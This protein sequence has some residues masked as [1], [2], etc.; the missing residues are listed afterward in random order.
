MR[1]SVFIVSLLITAQCFTQ[2]EVSTIYWGTCILD[3]RFSPFQVLSSNAVSS[4][5]SGASICDSAGNLLFYSNGGTSPTSN[6]TGGA[7][8]ANGQFLQN[9]QNLEHLGCFS[10]QQ[11]AIILPDPAGISA[12]SKKYYLLTKD[13]IEAAFTGPQSDHSG[14]SYGI[15]D[16]LA[17]GGNGAVI[18]QN[19]VVV[20]YLNGG[21]STD[22]EPLNVVLDT[23]DE[24]KSGALGYW[25]YSYQGDSLYKIHFGVNGFD[26]FQTLFQEGGRIIVAPD[27]THL[28]I[29]SRLY[30]LDA[31][32]G[33][34]VLVHTFPTTNDGVFSSDGRKIY[35]AENN[36]LMQYNMDQANWQNTPYEVASFSQTAPQFFLV[37]SGRIF[38]WNSNSAFSAQIMCPNTF[39]PNCNYTASNLSL[40]GGSLTTPPNIPAH[41]LYNAGS[42]CLLGLDE[43]AAEKI[44]LVPNPSTGSFKVYCDQL[45]QSQLTIRITDLTGRVIRTDKAT[46]LEV[47]GQLE[48][49]AEDLPNGE[50][51]LEFVQK[52]Q[53]PVMKRFVIRQ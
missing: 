11:G 4:R 20:P 38:L 34:L 13:C 45:D 40:Q 16:M 48:I 42:G 35:R 37:P 14:L 32:T 9:G 23:D 52:D 36:K 15:I 39:G 53:E 41:Y 44:S 33:N 8:G 31:P 50:Y 21:G 22:W 6:Y 17:N 47:E 3:F 29:K 25:V 7:W 27:R 51:F 28:M 49:H 24:Q 19:N 10:T 1:I 2:N 18:S 30:E 5:E 43:Q 26:S 46:N 12:T